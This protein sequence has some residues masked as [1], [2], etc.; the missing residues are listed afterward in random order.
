MKKGQTPPKR[1]LNRD[2]R[3]KLEKINLQIA[4]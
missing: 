3:K 2:E 1:E 4:A